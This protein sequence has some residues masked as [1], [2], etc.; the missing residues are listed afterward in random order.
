MESVASF[1]KVEK[2]I[3]YLVGG[4]RGVEKGMKKGKVIELMNLLT[5]ANFS[6]EEIAKIAEITVSFVN[7]I[8]ASLPQL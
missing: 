3:L 1:Y 5:K 8:K 6:V 2:D 4:R 7:K